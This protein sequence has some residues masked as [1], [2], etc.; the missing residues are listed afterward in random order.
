[1]FNRLVDD[2]ARKRLDLACDTTRVYLSNTAPVATAGQFG[3]PPEISSAGNGYLACGVIVSIESTGQT[4]GVYKLVANDCV[5]TATADIGPWQYAVWYD[6]TAG[7]TLIGWWDYGS[8]ITV[9]ATETL[10]LDFSATN[11][12]LQISS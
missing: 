1:M 11:G 12:L 10:T 6:V 3:S 2:L 8:S 9:H 5:I 4:S 7:G